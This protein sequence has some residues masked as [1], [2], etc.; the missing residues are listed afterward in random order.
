MP[1]SR[2]NARVSLNDLWDVKRLKL[3]GH[4]ADLNDFEILHVI[5]PDFFHQHRVPNAPILLAIC[6]FDTF[7]SLCP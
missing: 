6:D 3:D 4:M 1:R 7:A 5:S 2:P